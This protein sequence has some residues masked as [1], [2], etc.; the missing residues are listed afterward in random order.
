MFE[1]GRELKRLFGADAVNAPRDGLT[2]GD[3]SLLEL[4]RKSTRLNSSHT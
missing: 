3:A 2:G 4:D 1:F